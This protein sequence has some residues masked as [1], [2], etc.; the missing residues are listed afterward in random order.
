MNSTRNRA[1]LYLG[2]RRQLAA[3]ILG[4]RLVAKKMTVPVTAAASG[5]GFSKGFS[6]GFK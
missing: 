1:F 4:P 3:L 2:A 5:K 6:K